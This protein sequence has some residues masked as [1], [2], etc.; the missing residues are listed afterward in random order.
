VHNRHFYAHIITLSTLR[1]PWHNVLPPYY[2][3]Q[4]PLSLLLYLSFPIVIDTGQMWKSIDSF[5]SHGIVLAF[6]TGLW[7]IDNKQIRAE[8][9]YQPH[10]RV[11]QTSFS[12]MFQWRGIVINNSRN[13]SN[14]P[15]RHESQQLIYMIWPMSI[16]TRTQV[17][18]LGFDNFKAARWLC[19]RS[20]FQ[21]P[22]SVHM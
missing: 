2:T 11:N 1:Y 15:D 18:W 12:V 20:P 9:V 22:V 17:F 6:W 4:C 10:K 5:L 19:N 8:R 21:D 16:A 13:A 14:Q 7:L 3:S